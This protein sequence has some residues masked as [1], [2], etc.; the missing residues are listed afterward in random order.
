MNHE[1]YDRRGLLI[2]TIEAE[3]YHVPA[4]NVIDLS[5]LLEPQLPH[6]RV[7]QGM[8]GGNH[9]DEYHVT[10][11]DNLG[12]KKMFLST[13]HLERALRNIWGITLLHDSED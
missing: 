3:E 4:R 9:G 6:V 1:L 13:V 12:E 7:Y 2:C 8:M 5:H 10:W 11:I